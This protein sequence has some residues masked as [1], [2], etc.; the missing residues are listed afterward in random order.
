M[1][2]AANRDPAV[3]EDPDRFDIDRGNTSR[4][5]GF[6]NG[7]HMCLGFRLAKAEVRI[8]LERLLRKLP[9]LS[10]D[11]PRSV[12]PKGYEFRQ[13]P[14]LPVRWQPPSTSPF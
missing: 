3:F 5:L 12:P 6:A 2:G 13:P 8:A 11:E 1:L 9:G 7:S 14:V 10:L 4:H